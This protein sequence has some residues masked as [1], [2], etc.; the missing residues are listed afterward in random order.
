[1]IRFA[2]VAAVGDVL[3]DADRQAGAG[4]AA[5]RRDLGEAEPED[6]GDHPGADGEIGAATGGRS[7]PPTGIATSA[8]S[9]AG[10]RD[11]EQRVDA[12]EHGEGEQHVAAEADIGLLADRDEA[13]IAGEQVPQAGEREVE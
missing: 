13:G 7:G 2:H 1:M 10:D 6:L 5:E 11:G 3:D 8:P 9:D 4:A 12:D